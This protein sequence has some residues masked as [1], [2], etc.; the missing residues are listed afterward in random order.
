MLYFMKDYKLTKEELH[1]SMIQDFNGNPINESSTQACRAFKVPEFELT[2]LELKWLIRRPSLRSVKGVPEFEQFVKNLTRAKFFDYMS[3]GFSKSVIRNYSNKEVLKEID[4]RIIRYLL[5][6]YSLFGAIKNVDDINATVDAILKL[7]DRLEV[8]RHFEEY[9]K[10]R[11]Q[12]KLKAKASVRLHKAL[13]VDKEDF[14]EFLLAYEI[15]RYEPYLKGEDFIE[16]LRR[17][18][19]CW[20]L[21]GEELVRTTKEYV[22]DKIR[23]FNLS[24]NN[25]NGNMFV[26]MLHSRYIKI[27]NYSTLE[28]VGELRSLLLK[29]GEKILYNAI[30]PLPNYASLSSLK[31]VDTTDIKQV[32]L[33]FHSESVDANLSSLLKDLDG[34]DYPLLSEN[35]YVTTS[36]ELCYVLREVSYNSVKRD[37]FSQY[38]S[39]RE[40]GDLL[41]VARYR[42][43]Y[44]GSKGN[45]MTIKDTYLDHKVNP[46]DMDQLLRV[47]Q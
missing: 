19:S 3:E 38:A 34:T 22:S 32:N 31:A 46:Y 16:L 6:K 17:F 26:R 43:I 14:E 10:E 23:E 9:E 7:E 15:L 29:D 36:D 8:A 42:V 28:T 41:S 33:V 45:Q 47:K 27:M 1:M 13:E 35:T 24:S 37:G 18:S 21:S 20:S 30:A 11:E 4:K 25:F 44:K 5:G 40:V 39:D 12:A 2:D